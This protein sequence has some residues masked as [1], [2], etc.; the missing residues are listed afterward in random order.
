MPVY[1][2]HFD[3]PLAHARHYIGYVTTMGNLEKRMEYHRTGNG[4]RLMWAV[5][6]AGI[7]WRV[8]RVWE[9]GTQGDERRLK[10]G[11][12]GPKL[13]PVCREDKGTTAPCQER[14]EK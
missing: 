1:L 6:L 9:N 13:C 4:S 8:V 7:E 14:N 12:N 11:K 10:R 5:T 2:I 3:K